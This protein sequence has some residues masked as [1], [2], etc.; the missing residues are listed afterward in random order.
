M[1]EFRFV[2]NELWCEG[3]RLRDAA[4][5][6]GTPLY[7]YSKRSILD[8]CR[9]IERAFG[10]I[11][12]LSCYAVKANGNRE[13]LGLL[14]G[15]GIGA[16]AGSVGEMQLALDAGFPREKITLSGV[17]KRDD[18]IEFALRNRILALNVESE[19]ELEIVNDIAFRLHEEAR[20]FLR[21]NFDI[22]SDTHPYVTTGRKF[23]K[24]GVPA[25]DAKRILLQ[26]QTLSNIR[27]SGIHSHI[28]SQITNIEA[29]V[30][31]AN[32]IVDLV[33]V[34]RSV[35]LRIDQLNFGGGFGV[36][37]HDYVK[38]PWLVGDRDHREEGI[39]TVAML[40]TV[41]PILKQTGS[42]ILIQPGRSIVAHAGILLT[43]VL[44]KK[45]ASGK[46]FVIID[47]GMNDLIRPSL[48]QSYHQIV[49]L[50]MEKRVCEN[51]DIVGP[52]C[53][54]GDF[55]AHDRALP[56]VTRGDF[57]GVLCAG[58]YGYVLSSNYNG[59][60]RAA[61]VMVDGD[62]FSVVT[63]RE[64]IGQLYAGE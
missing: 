55:F 19:Q 48:Y 44:F 13:I 62:R 22:G 36:Q 29:F 26:A 49:P 24:F 21:V 46:Q 14:A 38:H 9:W 17:G 16:D 54:S 56:V 5:Q 45:N 28:G 47:A 50:H 4:E 27:I 60:P 52:L 35:G 42:R 1:E 25:S 61:E 20:I 57:L 58:A 32:A 41:L 39:T 51:V 2:D 6:C 11:D 59:R 40:E 30:D 63:K 31:A 43:K 10:S 33:D 12:H 37:Y 15:T 18:E 3:V 53:E 23:N 7:V 34:L 64:T 8:H